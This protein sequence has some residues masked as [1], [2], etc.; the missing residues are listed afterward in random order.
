MLSDHCS[1]QWLRRGHKLRATLALLNMKNEQNDYLDQSLVRSRS[2][3]SLDDENQLNRFD[4]IDSTIRRSCD[5]LDINNRHQVLVHHEMNDDIHPNGSFTTT[6]HSGSRHR[7]QEY[8]KRSASSKSGTRRIHTNNNSV[9]TVSKRLNELL[10]KTNEIIQMEQMVRQKYRERNE[11]KNRKTKERN[12]LKVFDEN[13]L[14]IC[15]DFDK[16]NGINNSNDNI[17][18]DMKHITNQLSS[19]ISSN[20]SKSA[21]SSSHRSIEPKITTPDCK[22][23]SPNGAT[24]KIDENCTRPMSSNSSTKFNQ[25]ES[26][27]SGFFQN[28]SFD[29][30]AS[31]LSSNTI[32]SVKINK[33]A[34]AINLAQSSNDQKIIDEIDGQFNVTELSSIKKIDEIKNRLFKEGLWNSD[35]MKKSLQ[36]NNN[37]DEQTEN[38]ESDDES[39]CSDDEQNDKNIYHN[40]HSMI[41]D[42]Q[43][44]KDAYY[45]D[46]TQIKNEKKTDLPLL[47]HSIGR[48]RNPLPYTMNSDD[49]I[50]ADSQLPPLIMKNHIDNLDRTALTM[51][52]SITTTTFDNHSIGT[53][54]SLKNSNFLSSI[55]KSNQNVPILASTTDHIFNRTQNTD[56]NS[57]NGFPICN[58]TRLTNE[59]NDFMFSSNIGAS[60]LV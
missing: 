17:S 9:Q 20:H 19:S 21:T 53:T 15:Q 1:S 46:L 40:G 52:P 18:N 50:L 34:V 41:L 6:S 31:S 42:I 25:G 22:I 49:E 26:I 35:V 10:N 54:F 28:T 3:E 16:Y 51:H 37:F 8:E 33:C 2:L 30:D 56:N 29:P 7:S 43:R 57:S 55:S 60:S 13:L 14:K 59:S 39:E 38:D 45:H 23:Q 44:P 27:S 4:E 47:M 36:F 11:Y 5:L 48:N 12:R 58:R 24:S 32:Q